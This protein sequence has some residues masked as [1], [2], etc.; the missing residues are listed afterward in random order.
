MSDMVPT[1]F[2]AAVAPHTGKFM[3]NG[4]SVLKEEKICYKI[5]Y[6]TLCLSSANCQKSRCKDRIYVDE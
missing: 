5:V 1:L 3:K 6:H 2:V 4:L